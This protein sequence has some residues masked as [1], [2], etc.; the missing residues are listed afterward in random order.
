[1]SAPLPYQNAMPA[2]SVGP[3]TLVEVDDPN[4]YGVSSTPTYNV[5][6]P[7]KD[8]E[9]DIAPESV[10]DTVSLANTSGSKMVVVDVS[11][12]TQKSNG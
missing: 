11:Q 8:V 10:D 12:R 4:D 1:M 2:S 5:F 6:P 3:K 7:A 9:A